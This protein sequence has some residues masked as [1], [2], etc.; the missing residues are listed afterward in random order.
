MTNAAAMQQPATE[1][2]GQMQHLFPPCEPSMDIFRRFM[3]RMPL[4]NGTSGLNAHRMFEQTCFD[5]WKRS[6]SF[7][8]ESEQ[9]LVSAAKAFRRTMYISS[10][11][12][13]ARD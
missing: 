11:M 4:G 9:A 1:L 3:V 7:T 8:G 10:H 5:E 6:R 2:A 13:I 12:L